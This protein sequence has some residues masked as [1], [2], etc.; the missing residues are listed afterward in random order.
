LNEYSPLRR[1][2]VSPERVIRTVVGL[3]PFRA[4]GFRVEAE[5]L[6]DKLLVHNYGHGGCG[7]TLSWGTA[8]LATDL[9]V[10]S[11]LR[12][13]VAVIGC[14]AVGLATAR[15]LQ[16]RGY[17]VTIHARD[18]PPDTTSNV[19]GALWIPYLLADEAR[20][21]PA[22]DAQFE[23]AARF[24][25]RHFQGLVGDGYGVFWIRQYFLSRAPVPD[26][27]DLVMLR[28]LFPESRPLGPAEHPFAAAHVV[29]DRMM[30]IDPAVYL[31]RL[32][33]DF[34]AAGGRVRVQS[35]GSVAEVATLP[36]PIVVNCTGL[37][38]RDLFGDAELTPIKGQ[39][40]VLEPQPEV[41]YAWINDEDLYMF[42][43]RDGIL[44]GGTHE[45]GAASLEPDR[46]AERRILEGHRA[47]ADTMR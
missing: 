14:G 28:D 26:S 46:V 17:D 40:T 13:P 11:G 32:L 47:V 3:R 45:M 2:L 37:G 43:R 21:T 44:L 35:F 24:S 19:A 31:E 18:L 23:R 4:S 1:V 30:F 5:R 27:W 7:V 36:E 39:L 34:R 20:R 10:E 9:V 8:S 15:L 38:A 41:D 6:D 33:D 12:G 42:P 25:H 22:F 16:T 29:L